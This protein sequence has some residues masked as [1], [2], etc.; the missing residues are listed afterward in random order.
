MDRDSEHLA[1]GPSTVRDSE[2]LAMVPSTVRDSEHSAMGPSTVRDSTPTLIDTISK[3]SS[4]SSMQDISSIFYEELPD[5]EDLPPGIQSNSL[6]TISSSSVYNLAG[7]AKLSLIREEWMLDST[8][9]HVKNH[10]SELFSNF[11]QT[12]ID[13]S[14][15][16]VNIDVDIFEIDGVEI[17]CHGGSKII[18]SESETRYICYQT[19]QLDDSAVMDMICR[20][21]L[22]KKDRMLIVGCKEENIV[23]TLKY[24]NE[25]RSFFLATLNILLLNRNKKSFKLTEEISKLRNQFNNFKFMT[26]FAS[27]PTATSHNHE[28]IDH[29]EV[30][31]IFKNCIEDSTRELL[32]PAQ[33]IFVLTAN[34]VYG[35]KERDH[36]CDL[37]VFYARTGQG[38]SVDNDVRFM[39]DETKKKLLEQNISVVCVSADT[40][41]HNI[42]LT[43]NDGLPNNPIGLKRQVFAKNSQSV[44]KTMER[45]MTLLP[46]YESDCKENP[47]PFTWTSKYIKTESQIIL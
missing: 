7:L 43:T 11:V 46:K 24:T 5:I 36:I 42:L 32:V 2:H 12:I 44:T 40:A 47:I 35:R 28:P 31:M 16:S 41:N 29:L 9:D 30:S 8:M 14:Y 27:I 20:V 38:V 21:A 17:L 33:H 13:P 1:M 18:D 25:L 23:Y 19:E 37:P 4:V 34:S 15:I 45:L 39:V 6:V 3:D 26:I 10:P 22:H